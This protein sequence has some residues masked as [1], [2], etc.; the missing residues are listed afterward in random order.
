M[1]MTPHAAAEVPSPRLKPIPVNLS[2]ILTDE[3]ARIFRKGVSAAKSR[4]WKTLNWAISKTAHPTAKDSLRWLR[5]Y[6]DPN[7]SFNELNYVIT[8]LN[9]WPRMTPIRK[10]AEVKLLRKPSLISNP[11]AWLEQT[12]P[13]SGEGR[14][15]LA[16]A[17]YRQGQ[18]AQGDKWLK[19]AW[20]ESKLTRDLQ[21]Q[22]YKRHK[23][24]LTPEDHQLRA[25]Y[26]IW[27]G[28]RH[29]EKARGL[30]SLMPKDQSKV[31]NA[32]MRINRNARGMDAAIKAVP[33]SLLND[34]GFLYE[35]ARWRRRKKDKPY[36][37]PV[38][39]Q[40]TSPP[41][42]E[43][44]K[45]KLWTER[46]IMAYWAIEKKKFKDA[47]EL[48]QNHGFTRGAQFAEAEF[49]AGWLALTKLNKADDAFTH[50]SALR[51]GVTFPV[52]LSRA[53][54]WQ[55][56]AAEKQGS[57]A[58]IYYADAARHVNTYYG[59]L[60]AQKL[61][62]SSAYIILPPEPITTFTS[63]SFDADP[64][65]TAMKLFGEAK[66][67]RNYTHFSFYL[68]DEYDDPAELSLLSQLGASFGFMRPSIRAAKQASRLQT[69]LTDSGYPLIPAIQ[70]LP[71]KFDKA[72][73]YAIARQESEFNAKAVSHAKAYGLMQMINGTARSTARRHRISYSRS[74]M[75]SDI[76]YS[77]TLGAHHLNDLLKDFDGSYILAAAA[78]NA[79]GHRAR[80][81]IKTY[82]DPRKGQI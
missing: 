75:T 48:T 26:L 2:S 33:K 77:A 81:W 49:L 52:S 71:A 29:Y 40:I 18:M 41:L 9:D 46:K 37:L 51:N 55:G 22:I 39:K 1:S 53:G 19:Y 36:A 47:Y 11:V 63:L 24:R 20:R 67:E 5:A 28:S 38:Y 65:V 25:D 59:M 80:K 10:K 44:G 64:R 68:D 31:M 56:R 60:A 72:F 50:F 14:L 27:L 76:N 54:Y 7:V 73:V 23:D 78:Y 66:S 58:E 16:N 69:M 70:K 8:N 61:N 15:A 3:D 57:G 43:Q 30:L 45:K 79:G 34:T 62:V 13:V 35:R 42:S 17:Y 6:R 32:R 74:R 82:G 21:R 12:E 4:K